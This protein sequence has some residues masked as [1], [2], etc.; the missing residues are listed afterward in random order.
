MPAGRTVLA[1]AA[2][3]E[4]PVVGFGGGAGNQVA[5]GFGIIVGAG[6]GVGTG[7]DK[8]VKD[9]VEACATTGVKDE[10]AA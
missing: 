4:L 1:G 6:G 8:G 5:T 2:Q 10:V 3:D 9:V 7:V